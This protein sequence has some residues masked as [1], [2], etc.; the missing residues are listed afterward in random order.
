MNS[1][2]I[3]TMDIDEVDTI[4]M[5]LTREIVSMEQ[6]VSKLHEQ[7]I[8]MVS[9]KKTI[10]NHNFISDK[11]RSFDDKYRFICSECGDTRR[12]IV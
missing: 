11:D 2:S 7:R 5:S 6:R 9:Y 4:I 12:T 1:Q 8:R 3:S 10:C